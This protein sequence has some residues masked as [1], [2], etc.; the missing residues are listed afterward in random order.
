M[1]RG[2]VIYVVGDGGISPI[3]RRAA[4]QYAHPRKYP[5]GVTLTLFDY[6]ARR[7]LS[8]QDW[9]SWNG[10]EPK[11]TSSR[12]LNDHRTPA[13]IYSEIESIG[14]NT[15]GGLR[16]VHFF[17]HGTPELGFTQGPHGR[18]GK[19][20]FKRD[21]AHINF[22]A[23]KRA[24]SNDELI[25]FWGCGA[26]FGTRA[27]TLLY[28]ATNNWHARLKTQIKVESR[29]RGMY[30]R[31]LATWLGRTV[32]AAPPGWSTAMDQPA[33]K[34]YIDRWDPYI[35]PD[36]N[37]RWWRVHP[38]FLKGSGARFYRNVLK[39]QIDPVGYVGI[40]EQMSKAP[41]P[42]ITLKIDP[43]KGSLRFPDVLRDYPGRQAGN[44]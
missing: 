17:T 30:A 37:S 2:T 33:N 12:T 39:A 18:Y 13:D 27:D 31:R 23:F 29:I 44:Y 1:D 41:P 24:F 36:P 7:I 43:C 25:K 11:P 34:P 32:W 6:R 21:F 22:K 19:A 14:I 15:P 20:G 42:P 4:F 16:T 40:T 5:G 10:T 26:Q 35:G 9:R 38:S 28:C 3:P 8:Y